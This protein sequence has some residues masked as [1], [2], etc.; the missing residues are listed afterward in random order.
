MDRDFT[1]DTI[2]ARFLSDDEPDDD[3]DQL[4]S[5]VDIGSG[6]AGDEMKSQGGHGNDG[7]DERS[8]NLDEGSDND[9]GGGYAL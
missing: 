5:D 4:D 2:Q 7:D 9:V 3:K 8:L 1:N 6:S